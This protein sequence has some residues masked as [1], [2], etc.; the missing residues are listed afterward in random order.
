MIDRKPLL[1]AFHPTGLLAVPLLGF[2]A[3]SLDVLLTGRPP[4]TYALAAMAVVPLHLLQL[5]LD[6]RHS[7]TWYRFMTSP[8]CRL[9]PRQV[10]GL[11]WP[12]LL[13]FAL[14]PFLWGIP[15]ASVLLGCLALHYPWQRSLYD[16][17]RA[18]FGPAAG[19]A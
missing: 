19:S 7:E 15:V 10:L 11:R 6:H 12:V 5:F 17:S 1:R 18:E 9:T 14:M 13:N 8:P 3:A 16:R 2:A 4:R